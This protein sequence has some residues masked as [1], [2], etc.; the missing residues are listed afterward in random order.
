[1]GTKARGRVNAH[2]LL[3]YFV[4]SS[5]TREEY[6]VDLAAYDGNGACT[7]KDFQ[8]RIEPMLSRGEKPRRTHCKHLRAA[9]EDLANA[10]I[11]EFIKRYG[12]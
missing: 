12:D 11:Q 3:R 9:R 7:C 6:L 10:L 2:E 8:C 4:R 5:T 1:M